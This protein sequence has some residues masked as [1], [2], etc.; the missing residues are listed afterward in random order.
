MVILKAFTLTACPLKGNKPS[1]KQNKHTFSPQDFMLLTEFFSYKPHIY[2]SFSPKEGCVFC[3]ALAV[4]LVSEWLP[5]F[6][7]FGHVNM[8]IIITESLP[9][10]LSPVPG[11]SYTQTHLYSAAATED[12]PYST[13]WPHGPEACGSVTHQQRQNSRPSWFPTFIFILGTSWL[14]PGNHSS[15]H[16]VHVQH[17]RREQVLYQHHWLFQQESEHALGD[18]QQA[19]ANQAHFFWLPSWEAVWETQVFGILTL[20]GR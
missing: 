8:W 12:T 5:W 11:S 20:N 17:E 15:S 1:Q 4:A 14:P 18:P 9:P 10:P 16:H 3:E 2:F 6:S 19:S 7:S 13:G